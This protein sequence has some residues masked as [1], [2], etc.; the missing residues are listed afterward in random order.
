M[1]LR[2]DGE[3]DMAILLRQIATGLNIR[4][5]VIDMGDG[6]FAV[7]IRGP[8]LGDSHELGVPSSP[9]AI[10]VAEGAPAVETPN[11]VGWGVRN[12]QIASSEI[13]TIPDRHVELNCR[14]VDE[15]S[16]PPDYI[17]DEHGNLL[18][19]EASG[20]PNIEEHQYQ[21]G[22]AYLSSL[23]QL[24][25]FDSPH[26]DVTNGTPA[27]MHSLV[28]QVSD[29]TVERWV[30][31]WHMPEG[32]TREDLAARVLRHG[33]GD[34]TTPDEARE[35]A[36]AIMADIGPERIDGSRRADRSIVER[37]H[38][39]DTV[40]DLD[41][42]DGIKEPLEDSDWFRDLALATEKRQEQDD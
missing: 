32:S 11:D 13:V 31:A 14:C 33:R 36:A 35:L 12:L 15:G 9:A 38:H 29:E 3:N 42:H 10:E 6:L 40:E 26:Q 2:D 24:G 7:S 18:C 41:H 30:S 16:R 22:R 34:E 4:P 19:D 27:Y 37:H 21:I 5:T 23:R 39:P 20:A 17:V 28:S 25:I 1:S 8:D